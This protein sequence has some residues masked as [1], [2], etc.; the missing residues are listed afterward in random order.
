VKFKLFDVQI[1]GGIKETYEAMVN[2]V[3][4]KCNTASK[5]NGLDIIKHFAVLPSY[6]PDIRR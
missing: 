3:P 1:N 6:C 4:L 5:I 2:G